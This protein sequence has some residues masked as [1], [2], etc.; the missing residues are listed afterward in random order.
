MGVKQ[1]KNSEK[2]ESSS[3]QLSV[4]YLIKYWHTVTKQYYQHHNRKDP[5]NTTAV[6][7]RGSEVICIK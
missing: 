7:P 3:L 2:R 6:A 5:E 1:K 4:N